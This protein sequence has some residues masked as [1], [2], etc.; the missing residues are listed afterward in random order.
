[1]L[2]NLFCVYNTTVPCI[3]ARPVPDLCVNCG[4]W[5]I[6][7]SG[8]MVMTQSRRDPG[9]RK[10]SILNPGIEKIGPGLDSLSVMLVIL[11]STHQSLNGKDPENVSVRLG[12]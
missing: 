12:L 5:L 4:L 3:R 9:I 11:V 1:M 7:G 6:R 10:V 8:I 2:F